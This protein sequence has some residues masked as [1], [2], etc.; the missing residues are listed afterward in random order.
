ML[1]LSAAC[2]AATQVFGYASEWQ[3]SLY[4]KTNQVFESHDLWKWLILDLLACAVFAALFADA[5]VV[6]LATG[7]VLL[8]FIVW[9]VQVPARKRIQIQMQKW[10]FYFSGWF[11]FSGP[12]IAV[13]YS[14]Y[15]SISVSKPGPPEWVKVIVWSL[16]LLFACF[17][18]VMF[19]YLKHWN[20]PFVSYRSEMW[21]LILSLV[22]KAAL[23]FQLWYGLVMRE[24]RGLEPPD[25]TFNITKACKAITEG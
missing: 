5:R 23:A 14:F 22:S 18:A 16:V 19:W 2:I 4:T 20:E 21:Y 13:Y 10:V 6:F 8:A 25:P 24:N 15:D 11:V 9:Q 12:W 1:T 17:A 3:V 7:G